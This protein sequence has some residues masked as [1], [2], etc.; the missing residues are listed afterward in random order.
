M[1]VVFVCH[2]ANLTGAPK[3]G[4]EIARYFSRDTD[5]VMIVK[6]DGPLLTIP[7]Y[8][9]A[10]NKIINVN[11]SHEVSDYDIGERITMAKKIL[12]EENPDL[13]YVN[14]VAASDWCKAGQ[15]CN[16]PVVLHSHEMKNE[17]LSLEIVN[18]FK[19][20][21]PKYVDLLITVS[22]DGEKDIIEQCLFPFKKILSSAPGIDFTKIQQLSVE[23]NF[24][25]GINVFGQPMSRD[26]IVVS[27]CGIASKRKGCDIF[28]Q[29][30]KK[31]P[32]HN[33]LWIGPW[34]KNE[35]PG[36]ISF[37]DYEQNPI[38]NFYATNETM[39]PY[40][41]FRLTDIFVLTSRED[42][43]PLVL[44]EALFLSKLCIGFSST[45]GSKDLLNRFGVLLHGEVT[46]DRISAIIEKIKPDSLQQFI[47]EEKK[48]LFTME[49]DLEGIG[50]K[51]KNETSLLVKSPATSI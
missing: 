20:D 34:D 49:H 45:G 44:I 27:M 14:S 12:Q 38:S 46:A 23:E 17:L 4:F 47:S 25:P 24:T 11:T 28:F 3:V 31:L 18:I 6:K 13:L 30:A 33:F 29:V 15:E 39:N 35:A 21:L 48:R 7:E 51:I 32:E 37:D 8:R 9:H 22:P 5:V 1:K 43:N 10:F 40:P 41:Y 16:I 42:P 19:K 2:D 36:N 26:K 50:Q